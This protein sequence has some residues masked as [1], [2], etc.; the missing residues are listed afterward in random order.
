MHSLTRREFLERTAATATAAAALA[1]ALAAG[2]A[3]MFISLNGAVAPRVGPWPE[4]ARLAAR[5][6]YGGIDWSLG[7]VKMAGVEATKALLTELKLRATI[8]W[9]SGSEK[10]LTGSAS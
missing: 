1:P 5:I 8:G 3:G 6:G 2:R 9:F 4:F 7:P 10:W